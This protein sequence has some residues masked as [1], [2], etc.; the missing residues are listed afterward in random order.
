MIDFPQGCSACK[1]SYI[2]YYYNQACAGIPEDMA[3]CS[4]AEMC[5]NG[6]CELIDFCENNKCRVD[7]DCV[8]GI[9][10]DNPNYCGSDNDCQRGF[11]CDTLLNLC[12]VDVRPSP[13]ANVVCAAPLKCD[14]SNG[15][16]VDPCTNVN[17]PAQT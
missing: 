7:Q 9:C 16:C 10:V 4:D 1:R 14:N 17:C 8:G 13:C 11:K 2:Y 15:Q 5:M 12:I 6:K 3:Q